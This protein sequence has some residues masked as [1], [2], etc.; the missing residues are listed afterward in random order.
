MKLKK[1]EDFLRQVCVSVVYF[2]VVAILSHNYSNMRSRTACMKFQHMW[3][4]RQSEY[5][6]WTFI[7]QQTPLRVAFILTC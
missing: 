2:T 6:A 4:T 7:L 3:V 5:V 1:M